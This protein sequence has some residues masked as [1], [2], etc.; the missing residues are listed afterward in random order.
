MVLLIDM[1]AHIQINA[2]AHMSECNKKLM[3]FVHSPDAAPCRSG[4]K[5]NSSSRSHRPPGVGVGRG[6]A[7]PEPQP[8]LQT[9]LLS[10]P[11]PHARAKA[12]K[13]STPS[14][15]STPA[16]GFHV[17]QIPHARPHGLN[18]ITPLSHCEP[19]AGL[20]PLVGPDAPP[21]DLTPAPEKR[22]GHFRL[23]T[24]LACAQD[25]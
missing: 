22:G 9:P 14:T 6:A 10:A 15:P 12:D 11:R 23:T 4:L 18:S 2:L 13:P 21:C 17:H 19:A 25:A 20:C 8:L 7:E 16:P 24:R 5:V 3:F 1:H